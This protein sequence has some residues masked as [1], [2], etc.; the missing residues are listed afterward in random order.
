ML[1]MGTIE[2]P[3]RPLCKLIRPEKPLRLYD[4]AL[5]VRTHPGSISL[6]H[7]LCYVGRRQL[8]ILTP[9]PPSLTR[10]L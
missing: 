1:V 7:G 10:R 5:G 2:H 9:Q 8:T 4:L 3:T 6:S